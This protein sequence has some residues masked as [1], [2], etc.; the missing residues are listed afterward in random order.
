MTSRS[1]VRCDTAADRM[2]RYARMRADV[3][4]V[5]VVVVLL[6]LSPVALLLAVALLPLLSIAPA[7]VAAESGTTAQF[8]TANGPPWD[9]GDGVPP[10]KQRR[11]R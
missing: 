3:A 7:L 9:S 2:R 1:Q 8:T 5:V 4:V 6:D 10:T 11:N